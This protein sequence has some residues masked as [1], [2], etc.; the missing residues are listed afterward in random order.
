MTED[1]FK[2]S[3]EATFGEFFTLVSTATGDW[4]VKGFIDLYKNIYT[5]SLSRLI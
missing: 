1:T 3:L 5:I 4:T 2:T